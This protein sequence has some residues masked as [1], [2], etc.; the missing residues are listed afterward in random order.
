MSVNQQFGDER[1]AMIGGGWDR[2][3]PSYGMLGNRR[4]RPAEVL[5]K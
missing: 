1:L 3:N 2:K 5:A 4:W